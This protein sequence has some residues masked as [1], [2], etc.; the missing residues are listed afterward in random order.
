MLFDEFGQIL[1]KVEPVNA[2]DSVRLAAQLEY[3]RRALPKLFESDAVFRAIAGYTLY[4]ADGTTHHFGS[5][6]PAG[7]SART[8]RMPFQVV[9]PQGA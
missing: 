1:S 8:A 9:P 2:P 7:V 4:L 6:A 5:R 3:A